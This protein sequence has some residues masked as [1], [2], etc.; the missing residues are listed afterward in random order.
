MSQAKLKHADE[1][2]LP[3]PTVLAFALM[4][5][6]TCGGLAWLA[7]TMSDPSALPIRKVAVEGEFLHL[8]P[9]HLQAVVV[10]AVDAGFF[11]VDVAAIRGIL[12]DEPWIRDATIRRVWPD[13]LRVRIEEQRPVARWGPNALLNEYADIFVPEPA[14]I[15]SE[16][17]R[18]HGPLGTEMELLERYRH[19]ER[20]FAEVG[21]IPSRID[22]SERHAWTVTTSEGREIVLGRQ[23]FEIR[24]ERFLV[25]YARGLNGLWDRI[26]RVDLRYTNGFAVAESA[27]R[28]GNG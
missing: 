25:G 28:R 17:V 13:T 5:A 1:R 15:P 14:E 8:N 7:Q 6:A 26:G 12:L 18:L 27:P 2:G 9:N 22:L 16:L 11:G 21:L 24:L 10:G 23:S 20:R 19:L 3:S 4:L